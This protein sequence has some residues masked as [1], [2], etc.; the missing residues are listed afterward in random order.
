MH[1]IALLI[2]RYGRGGSDVHY[3]CKTTIRN[4]VKQIVHFLLNYMYYMDD[5]ASVGR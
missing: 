2:D 3:K 5:V 1:F 4:N